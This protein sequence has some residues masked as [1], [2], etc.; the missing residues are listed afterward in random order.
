MFPSSHT[1]RLYQFRAPQSIT[2]LPHTYHVQCILH[3]FE[4]T[5]KV[6]ETR[7]ILVPVQNSHHCCFF[8]CWC[9][10][11]RERNELF[12]RALTYSDHKYWFNYSCSAIAIKANKLY[13]AVLLLLI[14][15]ALLARLALLGLLWNSPMHSYPHFYGYCDC[16]FAFF[17]LSS[18]HL[19]I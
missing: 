5:Y 8:R 10:C 9:C 18:F 3:I 16:L 14:C 11:N 4:C 7:A 1:L 19:H 17:F 12:A 13:S 15:V 2:N 6:V